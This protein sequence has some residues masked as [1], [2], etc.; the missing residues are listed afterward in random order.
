ML[1]TTLD[2]GLAKEV[3]RLHLTDAGNAE[4]FAKV[5]GDRL[6]YVH[7]IGWHIWSTDYWQPD[8]TKETMRLV[9]E[10]SKHRQ[11]AI[12]RFETDPEKKID[13][14]RTALKLE[15]TPGAK[16]CLEF[17][18]SLPPFS[19]SHKELDKNSEPLACLN[20]T[21][22]PQFNFLA[23]ADQNDLITKCAAV[24]YK[25]TAQAPRWLKFLDEVFTDQKGNAPDPDLIAY[26]QK[27]L[28]YCLTGYTNERCLFVCH[29]EGANGKSTFINIIDYIL[30]SYAA[31][32]AFG[33]LTERGGEKTGHDLAGLRGVRFVAAIETNEQSYLD[34]AKLKRLTGG[35]E[36]IS[37]RFLYGKYFRYVPTYKIWMACNHKPRIRGTDEAIW[38]RIKLIP[39]NSRF[40][41]GSRNT[42]K[43][44]LGK[45]KAE[46]EGILAW[47]VQGCIKW[48]EEGLGDCNAVK[49]ST[50]TYRIGEDYFQEFLDQ[51]INRSPGAFTPSEDIWIR[52]NQWARRNGYPDIINT[53]RLGI[54]MSNKGYKSVQQSVQGKIKRGYPDIKLI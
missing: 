44:L 48:N 7:G 46:A 9:K 6:R 12:S 11:M 50:Y 28:G 40:S 14:L 30:G 4:A 1:T 45:L 47:M 24:A 23:D 26:I 2:Y 19:C 53:N 3:Y 21:L 27:A 29:G 18:Q 15:Q 38:D 34:E 39:F 16:H 31:T 25:D 42:D 5:Y 8:E 52:H 35:E 13:N 41:K 37:V 43:E 32:I 33:N 17:A 36:P 54:A 20:G 22:Y 49:S 51:N 10:L